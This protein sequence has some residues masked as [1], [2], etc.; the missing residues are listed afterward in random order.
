MYTA[1]QAEQLPN[2]HRVKQSYSAQCQIALSVSTHNDIM[3]TQSINPT[4]HGG[5]FQVYH[6]GAT[7]GTN[8]VDK[9]GHYLMDVT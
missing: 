8:E 1:S 2:S 9:G 3:F 7:I 6:N 4:I 5:T